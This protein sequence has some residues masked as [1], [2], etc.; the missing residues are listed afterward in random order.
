[1]NKL[2]Y[3]PAY[4]L[5]KIKKILRNQLK[6]ILYSSFAEEIRIKPCVLIV[7]AVYFSYMQT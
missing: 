6:N 2:G 3:F 5:H 7:F 4:Y 1:V